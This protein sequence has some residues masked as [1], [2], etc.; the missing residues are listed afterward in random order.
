MYLEYRT[1]AMRYFEEDN[2]ESFESIVMRIQKEDKIK[3]LNKEKIIIPELN[4]NEKQKF[5]NKYIELI[6]N[7]PELD[8]S[9]STALFR[10][11]FKE[12][13]F[14][15]AKKKHNIILQKNYFCVNLQKEPA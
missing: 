13:E 4:D 8:V 11:I 14:T 2:S 3:R 1:N 15:S 10:D 6:K 7:R 12:I 5:I 9:N